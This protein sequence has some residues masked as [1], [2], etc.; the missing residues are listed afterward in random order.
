MW[1]NLFTV[2]PLTLKSLGLMGVLAMMTMAFVFWRR[3]R[4]EHYME[5]QLF[6]AFLVSLL[7]GLVVSRIGFIVFNFGVFGFN[8]NSWLDLS[9]VPG[10]YLGLGVVSAGLWMARASGKNKW[11]EFE[12]LDLWVTALAIGLG[13]LH[14]GLFLAGVGV[15]QATYLPWGMTFPGQLEAH[16]PNQL[17]TAGF[18]F[19]LTPYLAWTEYHYRTFGWYRKGK[20]A[21]KTG[22]LLSIFMILSGVFLLGRSFFQVSTVMIWHQPADT[23]FYLGLIV[24]GSF[25]LLKRAGRLDLKKTPTPDQFTL[26]Q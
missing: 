20:K 2:G 16:H 14:L 23:W 24:W 13:V 8:L 26:N 6:D 4:E 15:G 19:A 9:G 12:I 18:F 17:Y 11:D 3:G 5:D 7:I 22:F 25:V 1:P 21:A 10:M